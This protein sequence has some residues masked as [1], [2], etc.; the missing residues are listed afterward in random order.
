MEFKTFG[1]DGGNFVIV[2][3]NA[4]EAGLTED[5]YGECNMMARTWQLKSD[6]E[7]IPYKIGC[8][9]T[10]IDGDNYRCDNTVVIL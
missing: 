4:P 6:E 7:Y 10:E 2:L 9:R 3:N 8:R 1:S 5:N